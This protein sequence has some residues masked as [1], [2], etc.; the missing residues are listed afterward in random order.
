MKF[1]LKS[2]DVQQLFLLV[3]L[4][5]EC[6]KIISLSNDHNS[7]MNNSDEND[8]L[9]LDFDRLWKGRENVTAVESGIIKLLLGNRHF[10]RILEVGAGNGRLTNN[11]IKY[12]DNYYALDK[13]SNFLEKINIK[14][15]IFKVAC[16][17]EFT[18]FRDGVFDVILMVRVLN[19]IENPAISIKELHRILKPGGILILSF[20][21]T[22]SIADLFDIIINQRTEKNIW[23]RRSRDKKRVKRSNFREFFF[24]KSYIHRI[25][26]DENLFINK[27]ASSGLEDYL[28]LKKLP[29]AIFIKLSYFLGRS[30]IAPHTFFSVLNK[31]SIS[32]I[33]DDGNLFRCIKCKQSIEINQSEFNYETKCPSCGHKI[34]FNNGV[35]LP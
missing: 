32:D 11:L 30:L 8:F 16:D 9:K 10:G 6:T 31:E 12:C 15:G 2:K 13:I 5:F 24:K 14:S 34:I 3:P 4:L 18:P 19:F 25:L 23:A 7:L 17:L 35:L 28:F 33:D 22:G 21:H 1:Q 20:Y 29:P 26:S 27:A